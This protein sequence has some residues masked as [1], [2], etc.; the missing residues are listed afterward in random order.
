MMLFIVSTTIIKL[1]MNVKMFW[2]NLL[3]DFYLKERM[4]MFRFLVQSSVNPLIA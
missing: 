4:E 3:V 1:K 2:Y